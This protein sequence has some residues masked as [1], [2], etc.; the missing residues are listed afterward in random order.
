MVDTRICH[1]LVVGHLRR[2]Q[3]GTSRTFGL[4][5]R[6]TVEMPSLTYTRHLSTIIAQEFKG[7]SD[8]LKHYAKGWSDK[9]PVSR[10]GGIGALGRHC[11]QLEVESP[12]S[13]KKGVSTVWASKRL[14][15]RGLLLMQRSSE[16]S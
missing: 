15:R 12:T 8:L 10:R 6:S 3:L 14:G 13:E 5:L 16:G 11:R 1:R 4:F 7:K 2:S 9:A